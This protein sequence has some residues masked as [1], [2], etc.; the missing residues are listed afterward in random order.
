M[1]LLFVLF[2]NSAIENNEQ[3][4]GILF[5]L[6]QFLFIALLQFIFKLQYLLYEVVR[7]NKQIRQTLSVKVVWT[8]N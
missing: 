5:N 8:Y 6:V 3:I 7:K 2:I 4:L 1:Q